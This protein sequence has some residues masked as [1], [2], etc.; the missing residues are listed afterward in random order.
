[1]I[2]RRW[3]VELLHRDPTWIDGPYQIDQALHRGCLLL[4]ALFGATSHGPAETGLVAL[5]AGV[6]VGLSLL[7]EKERPQ[8]AKM[9]GR[10]ATSVASR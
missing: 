5:L 7:Y 4:A 8:Q 2:D 1:M 10:S 6:P 3:L 9:A